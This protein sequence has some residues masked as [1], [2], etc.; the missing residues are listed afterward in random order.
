M[1]WTVHS[2]AWGVLAP[3]ACGRRHS[4]V[5]R[6]GARWIAASR[7]RC[8]FDVGSDGAQVMLWPLAVPLAVYGA[9]YAIAWS[10]GIAHWSPGGGKWTTGPQIAA[11]LLVNLSILGVFGTFTAMGEEIGWRGYLQPRLDAA[12]VRGS[13]TV[14][15]LCQLA[16]HA[17]LM[18]GAG[19]ADAG[20]L[21]TSL[22]LFAAGDLPVTFLW[23][24]GR[25]GRAASGRR[26][27][28]TAFT[29]RSRSGCSR[30]SSRAARRAMA[31]RD[32]RS[33]RRGLRRGGG[34]AL[35]L[36]AVARAVVAGARATCLWL[37][38]TARRTRV[39]RR[40]LPDGQSLCVC[41]AA[42]PNGW[43]VDARLV[44]ARRGHPAT[45]GR[46]AGRRR[47]R[48]DL[49]RLFR[50]LFRVGP[51]FRARDRPPA[52]DVARPSMGDSPE[53]IPTRLARGEMADVVILDGGAADELGRRGL[54]RPDTKVE[55]AGSL[56]GMVVR[57]GAAKPDIG[58]VETVQAHVA[59][60]KVHRVFG[61]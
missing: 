22:A 43:R 14:V 56:I 17:P 40:S 54:V 12:G 34:R 16:Y 31:R 5:S 20:G 42:I 10:A 55:L 21:S 6:P 37:P 13:V 49:G 26:S 29:T 30:S 19:Y 58:S 61:Q 8:R 9:A 53:A 51:G 57:A 50:G 39:T 46:T 38:A 48:D 15:W 32:G 45:R 44:R 4:G 23:A 47:A 1:G 33:P 25:T 52:G 35:P 18:A 59:R 2:P 27:S 36:D 3:I 11:N 28:S 41:D 7:P 60:R 24:G